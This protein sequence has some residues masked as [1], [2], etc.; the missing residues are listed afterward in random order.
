M[1]PPWRLLATTLAIV[2]ASAAA[3]DP[4]A[5]PSQPGN[6]TSFPNV[7]SAC[8]AQVNSSQCL[9]VNVTVNI[10][11]PGGVTDA[12]G[13]HLTLVSVLLLG[14]L[15][16]PGPNC[17]NGQWS[18]TVSG[19]LT[20]LNGSALY[21]SSAEMTVRGGQSEGLGGPGT[22][23]AWSCTLVISRQWCRAGRGV[24][25]RWGGGGGGRGGGRREQELRAR[26][27]VGPP[28]PVPIWLL[29]CPAACCPPPLRPLVPPPPV[30]GGC[31]G[32]AWAGALCVGRGGRGGALGVSVV[33]GKPG[34]FW[35]T[36]ANTARPRPASCWA[37][38]SQP[39]LFITRPFHVWAHAA[40][41]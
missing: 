39:P 24:A 37:A 36:S 29:G 19:N 1:A 41:S 4:S 15:C 7:T 35:C 30:Y 14:P 34:K 33:V 10:T 13:Q 28:P 31:L 11:A 3:M 26:G 9:L 20:L 16:E 12:I 6:V 2:S 22:A 25:C 8:A 21:A 17:G 40:L 38:S 18:L 5:P 27:E 32:S 23:A